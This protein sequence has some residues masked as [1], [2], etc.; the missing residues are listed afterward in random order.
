MDKAAMTAVE[1]QLRTALG[2]A[3]LAL[4]YY[5]NPDTYAA[6][7]LLPDP[8]CGDFIHDVSKAGDYGRRMP[9][10]MARRALGKINKILWPKRKEKLR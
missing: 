10:K 4:D 6:I 7:A 9:G 1:R 2:T 8:P 5:A 3:M